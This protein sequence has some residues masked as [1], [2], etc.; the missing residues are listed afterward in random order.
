MSNMRERQESDK[1]TLPSVSDDL[2][3]RLLYEITVTPEDFIRSEAKAMMTQNPILLDVA[4]AGALIAQYE[5]GNEA[6]ILYI[7][8]SLYLNACF[9]NAA[10][11]SGIKPL[12][13]ER[14][15]I[16]DVFNQQ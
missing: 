2:A 10:T 8:P 3:E 7:K 15:T 13:L 1:S 5:Y 12:V 14:E 6:G 16:T 11:R 9:R 4:I